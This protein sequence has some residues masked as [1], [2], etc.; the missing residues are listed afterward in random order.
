[1]TFMQVL[2]RFKPTSFSAL[3]G[4][5]IVINLIVVVI[6]PIYVDPAMY[7]LYG[8]H[9]AWI[10]F[11]APPLVAWVTAGATLLFGAHAWVINALALGTVIAP[12]RYLYLLARISYNQKMSEW[13]TL[14]W[15]FTP[16][17][18]HIYI[19]F[20]WG[21]NNLL[22]LFWIAC[23]YYFYQANK[24]QRPYYFYS[25]AI[26]LALAILSHFESAFLVLTLL[27]VL[28]I[29]P[30]YHN[31]WRNKHTYLASMLTLLLISPYL[32]A[33]IQSH[34]QSILVQFTFHTDVQKNLINLTDTLSF[35]NDIVNELNFFFILGVILI[36][37]N[38]KLVFS[39]A[40]MQY[41]FWCAVIIFIPFLLLSFHT[42]FPIKYYMP[43][44]YG[45][46][47]LSLPLITAQSQKYF[48]W[49]LWFNILLF[50]L[51]SWNVIVPRF[52]ISPGNNIFYEQNLKKIAD[53][54]KPIVHK[55]DLLLG[56]THDAHNI[57]NQNEYSAFAVIAFYLNH[58]NT[59]TTQPGFFIWQK[60]IEHVFSENPGA[61]VYYLCENNAPPTL[62][63]LVCANT[64]TIT[65]SSYALNQKIE[66]SWYLQE[67]HI[68]KI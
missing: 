5:F 49:I 11:D 33:L 45:F 9:S 4:L 44:Y 63:G 66:N 67:C 56:C 19:R 32:I 42:T 68:P 36:C 31:L 43:F 16:A 40:K 46:L 28:I 27:A 41:F 1:M 6:K 35:I 65:V 39:D 38:I 58:A 34:F 25:M 23:V 3:V 64:K 55:N 13:I 26:M 47:L 21:Y 24:T 2:K 7:W 50:I 61:N 17:I 8:Q 57:N 53:E 51:N 37:K 14:A 15:L 54:L 10:Y 12:A 30:K 22:L 59:Y 48:N 18:G 62:T 20:N 52:G 29:V 60:K